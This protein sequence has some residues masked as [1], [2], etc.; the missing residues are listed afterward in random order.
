MERVEN[1]GATVV[2]HVVGG[3]QS[4]SFSPTSGSWLG[5]SAGW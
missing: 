4:T 2:S 3:E 1:H 5:G